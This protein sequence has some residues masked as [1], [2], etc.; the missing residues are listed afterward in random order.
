MKSIK[1]LGAG[2]ANCK[3][4]Y[5]LVEEVAKAKGAPSNW[6][7]SRICSKSCAMA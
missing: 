4:T 5:A 1:I 2:C 6:K 7:R 3:S